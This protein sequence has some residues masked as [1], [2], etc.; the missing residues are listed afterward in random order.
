MKLTRMFLTHTKNKGI[1]ILLI[2]RRDYFHGGQWVSEICTDPELLFLNAIHTPG[3]FINEIKISTFQGE[4]VVWSNESAMNS[5]LKLVDFVYNPITF[6]EHDPTTTSCHEL[7]VPKRLQTQGIQFIHFDFIEPDETFYF[8]NFIK[9]SPPGYLH[10]NSDVKR[11]S[12]QLEKHVSLEL[13]YQIENFFTIGDEYC[14][15]DP[16]YNRDECVMKQLLNV[17]KYQFHNL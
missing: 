10:Q 7:I 14:D 6:E 1:F 4:S 8:D 2:F 16:A 11:K 5:I 15:P 3:E 17:K 12:I 13:E 9:I